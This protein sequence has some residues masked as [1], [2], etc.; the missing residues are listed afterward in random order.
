MLNCGNHR[1]ELAARVNSIVA[2]LDATHGPPPAASSAGTSAPTASAVSVPPGGPDV[3]REARGLAVLLLYAAYEHLLVSLCRSVLEAAA[4][5]G[6]G[7]RRLQPGLKLFAAHGQLSSL[8]G[9]KPTQV[10]NGAGIKLVEAVD[11]PRQC[12]IVTSVFPRDGSH[13]RRKQVSTL[14]T[15]LGLGDPAPI[16]REVWD[17]IDPVVRDRNKI[18]HGEA[19]ADEVG[20]QY[21]IGETR[22]LVAL[23]HQRWGEFLD[24]VERSASTRSFYRL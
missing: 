24:W 8:A 13:M 22:A 10:W 11:H 19:T 6:V 20:R 17:K 12:T 4:S 9:S 7:N 1:A 14:C 5:L 23:W 16:L 2:L 15:V 18:A 3:S 21:T